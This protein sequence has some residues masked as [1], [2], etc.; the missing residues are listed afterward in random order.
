MLQLSHVEFPLLVLIFVVSEH[1]QLSL[2]VFLSL[3]HGDLIISVDEVVKVDRAIQSDLLALA[4]LLVLMI[5]FLSHEL[6]LNLLILVKLLV[7]IH[8]LEILEVECLCELHPLTS[9]VHHP[10]Q[11]ISLIVWYEQQSQMIGLNLLDV[12]VVTEHVLF[13]DAHD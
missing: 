9:V 1:V 13:L 11:C 3:E 4:L 8:Q 2:N 10:V 6:P 7:M 5:G 12:L